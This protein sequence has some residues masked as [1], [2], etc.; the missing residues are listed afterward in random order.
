MNCRIFWHLCICSSLFLEFYIP[1]FMCLNVKMRYF[2]SEFFLNSIGFEIA[3]PKTVESEKISKQ[4][5]L[6]KMTFR[7]GIR[8]SACRGRA[9]DFDLQVLVR[10]LVRKVIFLQ[11]SFFRNFFTSYRFW[12][13]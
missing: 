12:S 11:I 9:K 6:Q 1:I 13:R 4:T 7:T 3:T 10:I 5:N 8:T 2:R